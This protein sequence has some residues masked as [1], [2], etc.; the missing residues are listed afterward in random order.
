MRRREITQTLG[1]GAALIGVWLGFFLLD[2]ATSRTLWPSDA[3]PP[4][5]TTFK[6]D[7]MLALLWALLSV[8]VAH[9]H[10]RIRAFTSNVWVLLACHA[11]TLIALAVVDSVASRYIEVHWRGAKSLV[12]FGVTMVFYADFDIVSYLA[13][14]AVAETLLVRAAIA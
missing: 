13:I 10:K 8:G 4:L 2:T 11:P 12:P 3:P 6:I 5:A 14:I 9:W 1:T 7:L